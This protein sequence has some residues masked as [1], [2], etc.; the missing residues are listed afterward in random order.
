MSIQQLRL[1]Q[2]AYHAGA[3]LA[4]GSALHGWARFLDDA[5]AHKFAEIMLSQQWSIQC[6]KQE[7]IVDV[8][9]C[10]DWTAPRLAGGNHRRDGAY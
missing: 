10:V 2:A 7:R 9:T 6:Y 8:V 1:V 4:G 5:S 3:V